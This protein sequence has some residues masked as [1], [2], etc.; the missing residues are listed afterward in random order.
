MLILFEDLFGNKKSLQKKWA[1]SCTIQKLSLPL[2]C[3][4]TTAVVNQEWWFSVG[5]QH[6]TLS[7]WR[8]GFE[9]RI[10]Y[11]FSDV[12]I[13]TSLFFCTHLLD[14]CRSMRPYLPSEKKGGSRYLWHGYESPC[15]L[16]FS[17]LVG[18]GI[19]IGFKQIPFSFYGD[20][21]YGSVRKYPSYI[22]YLNIQCEWISITC[23]APYMLK[24]WIAVNNLSDVFSQNLK[25]LALANS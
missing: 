15:Y 21:A 4:I 1:K 14:N 5:V 11:T 7:R 6:A 22:S 23:V 16:C 8:P 3:S 12:P 17:V 2:H 13:G 19:L 20:D 18:R 24:N 25:Y 9:S 10:H